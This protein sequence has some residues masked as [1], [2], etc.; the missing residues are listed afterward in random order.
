[1]IHHLVGIKKSRKKEEVPEQQEM[2][3]DNKSD[4]YHHIHMYFDEAWDGHYD[5]ARLK[6]SANQ[7]L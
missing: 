2:C 3:I 1:M 5:V 4:R 7:L 6:Y